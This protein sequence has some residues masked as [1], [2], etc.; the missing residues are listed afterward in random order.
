MFS[1]GRRQLQGWTNSS[2]PVPVGRLS[3]GWCQAMHSSTWWEDVTQQIFIE[4][5]E[6]QTIHREKPFLHEGSQTVEQVPRGVVRSLSFEVFKT[7][8]IIALRVL[9]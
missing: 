8:L 9:V 5:R 7:Q 4:T 1:L 6:E 3:R 2:P